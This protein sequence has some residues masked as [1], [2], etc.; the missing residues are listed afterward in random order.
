LH[1][2]QSRLGQGPLRT[3][4]YETVDAWPLRGRVARSEAPEQPA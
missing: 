4:V 1:L 3:A 2:V